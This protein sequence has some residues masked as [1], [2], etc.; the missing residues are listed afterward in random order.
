L[1]IG[2]DANADGLREISRRASRKPVRGGLPNVLFARLSLED[3]PGELAQLADAITVLFPWGTLLRA[4]ALPEHEPLRKLALIGK[5]G[6]R[7]RF[8]HGYGTGREARAV[9]ELGLPTLGGP[10][11][12]RALEDAYA[13]AGLRAGARYVS[14]EEVTSVQTTWA[15]K[16]TF[17]HNERMFV[18]LS[19]RIEPRC[20]QAR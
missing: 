20:G 11:T 2:T 5:P 13:E 14:R 4:V 7:F 1:V 9:E 18:E 3:A 10:S 15:K 16:I 12:L 8:L 19:G 6:A 17:S